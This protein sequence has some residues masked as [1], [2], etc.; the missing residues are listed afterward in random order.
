MWRFWVRNK[1]GIHPHLPSSTIQHSNKN[2]T[3]ALPQQSKSVLHL[4]QSIRQQIVTHQKIAHKNVTQEDLNQI[5]LDH[6]EWTSQAK[7][8]IFSDAAW[9]FLHQ[10][11]IIYCELVPQSSNNYRL[12][13]Q[14]SGR[15][16]QPHQNHDLLRGRS[17]AHTTQ[18]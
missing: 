16:R 2:P 5:E 1:H 9:P 17:I 3:E 11:I 18:Y 14:K 7:A 4:T 10:I 8:A 6:Q 13:L 15:D 12:L